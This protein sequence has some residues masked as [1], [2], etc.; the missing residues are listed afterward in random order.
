[1]LLMQTILLL[2]KS[3][4]RLQSTSRSRLGSIMLHIGSM[5]Y[6]LLLVRFKFS[7]VLKSI[8]TIW[9]MR[10]TC[11]DD[12]ALGAMYRRRTPWGCSTYLY[13]RTHPSSC[14]HSTRHHL[15]EIKCTKFNV[16]TGVCPFELIAGSF[17]DLLL[18]GPD[19][20]QDIDIL[21]W[22]DEIMVLKPRLPRLPRFYHE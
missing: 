21:L 12:S 16:A 8:G 2:A 18:L 19:L 17:G 15:L 14:R 10:S 1:M 5:D 4:S 20:D 11:L 6:M 7:K 3:I 13:G 9:W 22:G